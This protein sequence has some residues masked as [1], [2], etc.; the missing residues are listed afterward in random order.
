MCFSKTFSSQK[1]VAADQ[2]NQ[3]DMYVMCDPVDEEEVP[4]TTPINPTK[5]TQGSTSA[6]SNISAHPS[7]EAT[8]A[9]ASEK[10]DLE[11]QNLAFKVFIL[12]IIMQFP[13]P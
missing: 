11:Y 5:P 8:P 12:I 2:V 9:T 13:A 3:P 7:G 6:Y 1:Q 4:P 10:P